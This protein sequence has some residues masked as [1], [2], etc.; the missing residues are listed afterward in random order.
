[1]RKLDH[2]RTVNRDLR[3]NASK[4]LLISIYNLHYKFFTRDH[5]GQRPN[6]SMR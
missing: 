5:F 1:M 3:D 6:I 4:P 2:A